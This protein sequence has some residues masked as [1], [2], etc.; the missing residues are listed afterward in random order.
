[1]ASLRRRWREGAGNRAGRLSS[2][3]LASRLAAV[4]TA[5]ARLPGSSDGDGEADV[6]RATK[7]LAK[8][9]WPASNGR[10]PWHGEQASTG[11]G[12]QLDWS[13]IRAVGSCCQSTLTQQQRLKY[14]GHTV[15]V[16]HSNVRKP[17]AKQYQSK[18]SSNSNRQ[19]NL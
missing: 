7:N 4:A 6:E 9:D 14:L 3:A 1:M 10:G 5:R 17:L 11:N 15:S 2:P 13:P 12:K 16:C 18:S 8:S 19:A